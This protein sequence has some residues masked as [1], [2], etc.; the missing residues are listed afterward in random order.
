MR[1][2]TRTSVLPEGVLDR[3]PFQRRFCAVQRIAWIV[4]AML[5]VACLLGLLGRGGA[6]SRNRLTFADRSV[7]Y[8]AVSRW[9]APEN[10]VLRFAP[11]PKTGSSRPMRTFFKLSRLRGSIRPR[12]R[13]SH[14]MAAS[15]MYSTPI[16]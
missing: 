15:A 9:N 3:S 7:D 16:R 8:P 13:V 14:A 12:R 4:F 11:R 6:F 5:L 1:K 10:V 2:T